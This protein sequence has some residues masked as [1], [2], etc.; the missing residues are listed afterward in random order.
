MIKLSFFTSVKLTYVRQY[1]I[2]LGGLNKLLGPE[3]VVY[4]RGG[5]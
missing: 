3:K 4:W 1:S 2:F 5:A